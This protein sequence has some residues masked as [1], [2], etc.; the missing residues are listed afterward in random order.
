VQREVD[1]LV[2]KGLISEGL[3]PYT[4][5]TLLVP[6]KV[7]SMRMC[8]DTR[9]INKIT[10]KHRYPIPR[11]EDLL[12]ELH[13]ATIFS[14]IDLRSGYC[15]TRIHE[16]VEWKRA[17]KAKGGLYEWLVVPFGHT[18]ALNTLMHLMNQVLKPFIGKFV[19]VYFNDILV[20]S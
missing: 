6:K 19:V 20:C 10:I 8:V 1:E 16:R 13:E 4:I 11:L 15:Q 18:N 3:S 17:F 14:K 7:G 12:Y 9:A 5:S 2:A